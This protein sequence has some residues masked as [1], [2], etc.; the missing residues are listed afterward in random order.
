[1][2][3]APARTKTTATTMMAIN[4]VL[5]RPPVVVDV[6]SAAMDADALALVVIWVDRTVVDLVDAVI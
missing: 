4:P 3:P 6:L 1:M 2:N 5:L